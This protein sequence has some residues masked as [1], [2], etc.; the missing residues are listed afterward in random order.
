MFITYEDYFGT[1]NDLETLKECIQLLGDKDLLKKFLCLE[2][3]STGQ[4]INEYAKIAQNIAI[5]QDRW[6]V[7]ETLQMNH[8][9]Y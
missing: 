9:V 2:G 6:D 3:S 1:N 4:K 7:V 8:L 5:K